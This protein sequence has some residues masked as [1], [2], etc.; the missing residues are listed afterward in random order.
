MKFTITEKDLAYAPATT[1][2]EL[3]K[4]R[5]IIP[6]DVLKAQM[7][8]V[9]KTNGEVNAIVNAYWERAM[10][11]AEESTRRYADGTYRYLEGITVGVKDEHW[12]EGW[13]VTFGSQI[14]KND[15]PMTKPDPIVTKLKAAG[16]IPVIQTTVP[17]LFFNQI[18]D[19]LAWGTTRNPWNLEFT[20]GASSG[21]LR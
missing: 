2:M 21:G 5:V 18:T 19:T 16:A 6:V 14:H 20:F 8:E 11:M 7:A 4:L 13:V 15:P 1:L 3:F 12:D 10:Q 17:E 9:D